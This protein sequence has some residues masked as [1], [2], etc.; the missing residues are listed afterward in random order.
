[1]IIKDKDGK[2]EITVD[3]SRRIIYEKYIGLWKSDDIN[4][5]KSD[6]EKILKELN[7]S[8][9]KCWAKICNLSEYKTSSISD[10]IKE[11]T[12]WNK[13]NGLEYCALV[14]PEST[15]VKMQLNR[16]G[17]KLLNDTQYFTTVDEAEKWI[18]KVGF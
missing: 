8:G 6:Y 3:R 2:Y 5:E 13:N 12:A 14:I 7:K 10:K 1:M 9:V 18:K 17:A 16:S 4:R 15:I 11:F